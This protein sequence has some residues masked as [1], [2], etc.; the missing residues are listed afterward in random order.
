MAGTGATD[1]STAIPLVPTDEMVQTNEMVQT[2]ERR[3]KEKIQ[4]CKNVGINIIQ[5]QACDYSFF[6]KL[7]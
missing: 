5:S 7:T 4:T 1:D 6:E 2:C 3:K